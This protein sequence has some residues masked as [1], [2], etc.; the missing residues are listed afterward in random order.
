MGM[1]DLKFPRI[2]GEAERSLK[3]KDWTYAKTK[4]ELRPCVATTKTERR[5]QLKLTG[6]AVDLADERRGAD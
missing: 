2:D 3:T 4:E 5:R 1:I 6:V